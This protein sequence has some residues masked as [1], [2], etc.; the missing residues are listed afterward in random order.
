MYFPSLVRKCFWPK[1]Y[2]NEYRI[3]CLYHFRMRL[4]FLLIRVWDY[5]IHFVDQVASH[6]KR[7]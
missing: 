6:L 2:W 4:C 5:S 7:A 1:K 3:R